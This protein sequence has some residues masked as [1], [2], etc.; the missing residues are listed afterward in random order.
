M[1]YHALLILLFL[2]RGKILNCHLLQI[3]GGT[4]RVKACHAATKI[5]PLLKEMFFF[6]LFELMLYVP[7]NNFAGMLRRFLGLNQY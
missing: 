5:Y 2:K 4:L 7:D 3:I 6:C 1:K